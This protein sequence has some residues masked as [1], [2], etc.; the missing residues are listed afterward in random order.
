MGWRPSRQWVQHFQLQNPGLLHGAANRLDPWQ[1]LC[2]NCTAI[3]NHFHALDIAFKKGIDLKDIYNA[4]KQGIQCGN[5]K[6]G[7]QKYFF[8]C[9]DCARYKLRSDNLE[10]VT[11]IHCVCANG[12][13]LV[14]TFIFQGGQTFHVEWFEGHKDSLDVMC[15]H[16][17]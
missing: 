10:L 11:I 1:A 15:V 17:P 8:G 7:R 6:Q 16:S 13:K 14:P 2:F 3:Q 5:R 4:N 12:S 9:E